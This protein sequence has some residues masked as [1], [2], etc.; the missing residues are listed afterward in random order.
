VEHNG[1]AGIDLEEKRGIKVKESQL[2][3]LF[4]KGPSKEQNV[5]YESDI[6]KVSSLSYCELDQQTL[7]KLKTVGINLVRLKENMNLWER[8]K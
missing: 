4:K 8:L 5:L 6:Y 7:G 1:V 2:A 3:Y